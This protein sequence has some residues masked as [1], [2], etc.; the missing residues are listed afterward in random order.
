MRHFRAPCV[1]AEEESLLIPGIATIHD[2]EIWK[3]YAKKGE[4]NEA[5]FP[6]TAM[7]A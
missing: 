7:R 6:P 4:V 5:F 3:M 1:P 2:C